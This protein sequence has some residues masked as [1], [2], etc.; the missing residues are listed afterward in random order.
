MC[1]LCVLC[2]LLLLLLL[3]LLL[4]VSVCVF[5]LGGWEGGWVDGCCCVSRV[6]SHTIR[7]RGDGG[8]RGGWVARTREQHIPY[9]HLHQSIAYQYVHKHE[10]HIYPSIKGV[11]TAGSSFT[12]PSSCV[13]SMTRRRKAPGTPVFV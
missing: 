7:V 5:L 8:R 4:C 12:S 9:I 6:I 3:L 13:G 2:V 11:L 1:V 10:Q